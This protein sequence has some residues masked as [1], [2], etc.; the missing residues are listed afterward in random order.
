[1]RYS[2]WYPTKRP[3]SVVGLDPYEFPGTVDAEPA[4]GHFGVVILSRCSG[5]FDLGHRDTAIALAKAGFIAAAPLHPRNNVRDDIGDDQR[6]VV[7][8]RPRRLSAVIDAHLAQPAWSSRIDPKEIAA[9]GFSAG[10]YTVLAALGAAPEF[11]RIL[12][13][14]ERHA[15]ADPYFRIINDVG[16]E[17]SA[18]HELHRSRSRIRRHESGRCRALRSRRFPPRDEPPCRPRRRGEPHHRDIFQA[19]FFG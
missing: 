17:V 4:A 16:A 1:M 6:I 14:C 12:D 9:F 11:S 18:P 5:G 3:N 8:G 19:R 13:H 7:D 10:A 15:E 2:L